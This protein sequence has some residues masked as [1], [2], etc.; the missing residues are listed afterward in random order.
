MNKFS[1]RDIVMG[2]GT[3]AITACTTSTQ[4]DI[5]VKT[6]VLSHAV[7]GQR[8]EE[9]LTSEYKPQLGWGHININ[10]RNLDRS[11]EFYRKLGFEIFI[12]SIPYLGLTA[13]SDA[14]PLG[15]DSATALGIKPG[16]RGRACI[17][18]LNE[19]FPKID[20]TEFADLE[21]S[22]PLQNSDL[23][24][25]RICLITE[26]LVGDVTHLKAQGVEF[27]SDPQTGHADLADLAVCKDPDGTLIELLQ[28]YLDRWEPFL[29]AD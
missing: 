8:E 9:Q 1:R 26:D 29:G 15:G 3:L 5:S 6:M 21:Q 24:L 2:T 22:P 4:G 11:I 17:M 14:K 25:V 10:V 13:G 27:V 20:L 16:K 7:D 12:P 19:G 23:G 18:Q 28:V